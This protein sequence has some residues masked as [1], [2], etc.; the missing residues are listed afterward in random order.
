MNAD[1]RLTKYLPHTPQ[2]LMMSTIDAVIGK[3]PEEFDVYDATDKWDVTQLSKVRNQYLCGCCWALWVVGCLRV[4]GCGG[5]DAYM[6]GEGGRSVWWQY[7]SR[8]TTDG[9][10]AL[11][12]G[13]CQFGPPT[14]GNIARCVSEATRASC[15]ACVGQFLA[16]FLLFL[17]HQCS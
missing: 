15:C 5:W 3:L 12:F 1:L 9:M 16:V 13:E 2:F 7:A 8:C 10:D 4:G 17:L 14:N 6:I 11:F